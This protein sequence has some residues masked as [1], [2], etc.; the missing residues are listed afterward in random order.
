TAVLRQ[1]QE[2]EQKKA[3]LIVDEKTYAQQLD[4]LRFQVNEIAGA[5][6]RSGEDNDIEQEYERASNSARLI[7]LS[8]SA[9]AILA[10]ND[11]SI[12]DSVGAVG[13]LLQDLQRTDASASGIS[14]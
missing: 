9:T 11:N 1:H 5:Q 12:L 2:L 8:E 13:R 4:L 6:L 14:A 7:E 10:E 3:D